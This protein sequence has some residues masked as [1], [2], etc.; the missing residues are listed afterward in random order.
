MIAASNVSVGGV[1]WAPHRGIERV[2]GASF[3]RGEL[4]HAVERIGSGDTSVAKQGLPFATD[5]AES[6]Q[7]VLHA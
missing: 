2:E 3:G 1:A 7:Q 5:V 6:D 4:R